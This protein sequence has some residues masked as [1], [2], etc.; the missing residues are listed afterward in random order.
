MTNLFTRCVLCQ[1][2]PKTW[3]LHKL[4]GAEVARVILL[5]CGDVVDSLQVV[6]KQPPLG[7]LGVT[8][9][10]VIFCVSELVLV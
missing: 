1:V 3:L 6:D 7:E 8:F 5:R 9:V 4:P 2:S 10:T